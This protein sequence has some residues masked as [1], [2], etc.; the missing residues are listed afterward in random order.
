[1][2]RLERVIRFFAFTLMKIDR[3]IKL[4]SSTVEMRRHLSTSQIEPDRFSVRR[5]PH[6]REIG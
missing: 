5:S 4:I 2:A 3:L 1:M 6:R